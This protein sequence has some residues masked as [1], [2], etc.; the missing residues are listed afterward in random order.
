[1]FGAFSVLSIDRI[2]SGEK[3]GE[4]IYSNIWRK[5]YFKKIMSQCVIIWFEL[6]AVIKLFAVNTDVT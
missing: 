1:M 2:D 3:K 5:N 6:A 4:K